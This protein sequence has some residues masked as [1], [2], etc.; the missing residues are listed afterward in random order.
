M[1]S[2]KSKKNLSGVESFG[3]QYIFSIEKT[4]I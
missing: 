1:V 3:T 4:G 2:R